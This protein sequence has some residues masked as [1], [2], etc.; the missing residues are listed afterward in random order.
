[1][2]LFRGWGGCGR[3]SC[4]W[5]SSKIGG[6]VEGHYCPGFGGIRALEREGGCNGTGAIKGPTAVKQID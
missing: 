6:G 3:G 4:F 1:M 2:W 5:G